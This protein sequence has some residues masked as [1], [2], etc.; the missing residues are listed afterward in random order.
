MSKHHQI[1]TN[2][3]NFLTDAVS[4]RSSEFRNFVFSNLNKGKVESRYIVLR[5]FIEEDHNLIFF[6]D[7][8]SPKLI[9]ILKNNKTM[10]LFYSNTQKIQLRVKTE[11]FILNNQDLIRKYWDEVPLKSRK[12]YSTKLPPSSF[13]N[14]ETD[15]LKKGMNFNSIDYWESFKNFSVVENY[16]KE[17]DFLS[18]NPEGHKR[19]R[20]SFNHKKV[21]IDWLIP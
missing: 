11:S 9:S 1:Y 3:L 10:C 14:F 18:L 17:I 8:R 6:T 4:N 12:S 15:G 16:I 19:A 7:K 5:D 20:V 13:S 2:A 21:I